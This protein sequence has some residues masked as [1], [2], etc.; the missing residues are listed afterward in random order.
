MGN[1]Q[2]LSFIWWFF[3]RWQWEVEGWK[4]FGKGRVSNIRGYDPS[5]NYE[6]KID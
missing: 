3:G 2:F 5:A 4:K 1:T 6:T